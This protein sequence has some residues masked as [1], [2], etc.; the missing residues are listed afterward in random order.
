MVLT[1]Y[2]YKHKFHFTCKFI[3]KQY[4]TNRT[5]ALLWFGVLA[6]VK[7][8]R[9]IWRC[10]WIWSSLMEFNFWLIV[11]SCSIA[12]PKFSFWVFLIFSH[13]ACYFPLAIQL[14]LRFHRFRWHQESS[15]HLTGSLESIPLIYVSM[16]TGWTVLQLRYAFFGYS[17]LNRYSSSPERVS[18]DLNKILRS[19][20]KRKE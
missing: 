6:I 9:K 2:L 10:F 18:T 19:R 8:K 4:T 12:N 11:I 14:K 1:I 5:T 17:S 13:F 16:G 15:H 20:L 7:Y 3:W